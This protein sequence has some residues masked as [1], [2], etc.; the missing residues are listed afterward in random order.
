MPVNDIERTW[1]VYGKAFSSYQDAL[2]WRK[3]YRRTN[4]REVI[5]SIV[6]T[7][8]EPNAAVDALLEMFIIK[9]KPSARK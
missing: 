4:L 8:R 6:K 9:F 2:L 7:H 3:E 5:F 1:S